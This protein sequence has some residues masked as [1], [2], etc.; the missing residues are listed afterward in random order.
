MNVRPTL[1]LLLAWA[2]SIVMLVPATSFADDDG[3]TLEVSAEVTH[4]ST[5]EPQEGKAVILRA[6]R[7][8]GPFEQQEP[9]P[10]HE[11]SAVT[12]EDGVA[13]FE[14]VPTDLIDQGLELYAATTHGGHT[15]KSGRQDATDGLEL[16]IPVYETGGDASSVVIDRMQT[17]VH[18]WED[19]LFL[20]QNWQ[21]SVD[22]DRIVDTAELDGARYEDG[23]PLTLPVKAEGIEAQGPGETE[24]V[25]STVHWQGTLE[26]DKPTQLTIQFAM[27]VPGTSMIYEQPLDYPAEHLEVIV[28]LEPRH[29]RL[30]VDYFEGLSLAAPGFE[31]DVGQSGGPMQMQQNQGRALVAERSDVEAGEE[32]A[33]KLDGLPFD[34]PI[35]GW[36]TVALGLLAATGVIIFARRERERVDESRRSG[37]LGDILREEREELLDELALLERDYRDGEVSDVEYERERL[38]LRERIALVMKRLRELEE[39]AA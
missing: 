25:D 38:L 28:P 11:F 33:F 26:P 17:V 5:D 39:E 6:A 22:G 10:V 2:A 9:E 18:V 24:V 13:T 34:K 21:L 36:I 15:F 27:R 23:L 4:G 3:D 35:A 12:N 37:E 1:T 30:Q 8:M 32:M 7:A 20:Q 14:D 31:V 19:N 16:S 29:E